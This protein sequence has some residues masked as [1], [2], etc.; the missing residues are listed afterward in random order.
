MLP[1]RAIPRETIEPQSSRNLLLVSV[2]KI[3]EVKGAER[4]MIRFE[5][6]TKGG[7]ETCDYSVAL[8]LGDV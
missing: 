5:L 6:Q 2:R 8:A 7:G 4:D 3:A 1:E